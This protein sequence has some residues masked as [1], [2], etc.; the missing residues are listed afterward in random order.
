LTV[1]KIK[2]H[3]TKNRA[4][5]NITPLISELPISWQGHFMAEY[6]KP[7]FQKLLNFLH[8][9]TINHTIFPPFDLWFHAFKHTNFNDLSVVI[10]GQ[11][12]YHN[13]EQANGLCFCV[14]DNV[15]IPP[16]LK[17]IF[18]E[19]HTDIGTPIPQTGNLEHWAKQGVLLLNS[20]LT[21]RANQAGSH[22]KQGWEIFTDSIIKKISD[23]TNNIVFLLWGTYAIKKSALIDT[24]KQC[25]LTSP[26]PSPLSAYRGFFGNHHFSKTNHY[27]Q[28]VGKKT[29]TW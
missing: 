25:I 23:D 10:L 13:D 11:D 15:G 20:T 26:H 12:P 5:M 9:E 6:D 24:T 27:L 29:I 21:V 16:S 1:I 22:Q 3:L 4:K 2:I 18:Q 19:I 8:T 28:S 14:N 17:N 7:Y